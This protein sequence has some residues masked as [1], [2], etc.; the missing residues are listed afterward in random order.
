MGTTA[1]HELPNY[2][3]LINKPVAQKVKNLPAMQET[4]IRFLGLEDPLEKRMTTHSSILAWRILW[5]EEPGRLQ[6]MVHKE[7]DMTEQI[8]LQ[9]EGQG[10]WVYCSPWSHKELDRTERLNNNKYSLKILRYFFI[11][12]N[13]LI[14]SMQWGR[15]IH[16]TRTIFYVRHS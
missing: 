15:A 14:Y 2:V 11:L 4:W 5:T 6:L 8:T 3:F 13:P 10:S 1:N 7:S 9:S 12:N 16:I